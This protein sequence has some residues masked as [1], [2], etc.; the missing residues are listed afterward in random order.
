MKN[1]ELKF[2]KGLNYDVI[3]V[4]TG[5]KN[6]IIEFIDYD[7][8]S[9]R[10]LISLSNNIGTS[11]TLCNIIETS[12]YDIIIIDSYNISVSN[13]VTT[14]LK[15]GNMVVF[16]NFEKDERNKCY[17]I[18]IATTLDDFGIQNHTV[19][20]RLNNENYETKI[21]EKNGKILNINYV[22]FNIETG[23]SNLFY[24]NINIL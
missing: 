19:I 15:I 1:K 8:F 2:K 22:L 17:G 21:Y 11:L 6:G 24:S 7:K 5:E 3:N 14:K 23:Y 16:E 20:I 9:N 18:I 10:A 12:E 4:V 13:I